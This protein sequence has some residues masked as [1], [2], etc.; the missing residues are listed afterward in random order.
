MQPDPWLERWL[1]LI[2]AHAAG[3]PVLE[4]GCGSGA[5]T[6]TL[7]DAG[8]EVVALDRS[9]DEIEKASRRVPTATFLVR[10]LREDFPAEAA[11]AGVIVA[12][13]SLHYLGWAETVAL[14]D[15]LALTLGSG[16]LLLCRLN[17]TR[18]IHFG[19]CGHPEIEPGFYLV[20]GQPKRF[21]DQASID[22]LVGTSGWRVLSLEHM[23]TDKYLAQKA[24]WELVCT[25]GAGCANA[26][27]GR[28]A[29]LA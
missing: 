27:P 16:G 4:I 2:R 23:L 20:D 10:D 14:F 3:S 18:D 1:P 19:A 6:A 29:R 11:G 25:P 8:L 15:R 9:P 12:S 21:F 22:T 13:L 7:V 28:Q 24:L 5:D 17:S 26:R